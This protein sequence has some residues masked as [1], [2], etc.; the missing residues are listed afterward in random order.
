MFVTKWDNKNDWIYIGFVR[1][2][3]STLTED[4]WWPMG[5]W[6]KPPIHHGWV[7]NK[8][9]N[10]SNIEIESKQESNIAPI[11]NENKCVLGYRLLLKTENTVSK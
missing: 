4:P 6:A 9:I 11:K 8:L 10:L 3:P 2:K 5:Y 7:A 1:I